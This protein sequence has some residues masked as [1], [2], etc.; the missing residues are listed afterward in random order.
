MKLHNKKA[1]RVRCK[2]SNRVRRILRGTAE[3]P[4][5]CVMK[6]N[7]HIYVQLINDEAGTTL[8][9]D[10]T[11]GEELRSKKATKS[12]ETAALLGASIAQKAL[13]VGIKRVIFDRGPS[14]YHGI[15]ATLADAARQTGIQF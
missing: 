3:C 11:V 5:L 13:G 4:R 8:L 15:L 12:K 1:L 10:S 9:S 6:S 14:T 2:R 7:R